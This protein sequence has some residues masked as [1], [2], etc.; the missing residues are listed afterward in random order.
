MV[1]QL[2]QD[3]QTMNQRLAELTS[4]QKSIYQQEVALADKQLAEAK[5]RMQ[6]GKATQDEV[7]RTQREVYDLKRQAAAERSN[8][9]D[10]KALIREEIGLVERLLQECRKR[11]QIGIEPSEADIP[12]QRELLRLKRE[13]LSVEGRDSRP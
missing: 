12:L 8:T 11:I 10:I 5:R 9:E 6:A 4:D 3:I 2:T 7:L 13:L 1:K